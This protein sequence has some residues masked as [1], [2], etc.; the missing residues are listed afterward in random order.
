MNSATDCEPIWQIYREGGAGALRDVTPV[1]SRAALYAALLAYAGG[2][3]AVAR[4]HAAR[5]AEMA[6]GSVLSQEI[7]RYLR[8]DRRD[9]SLYADGE[10][11]AAF[12]RGGGNRFLYERV[13]EA[14][15]GHYRR[16]GPIRLLDIG[17]G[18]G[19]ALLSA[20]DERVIGAGLVGHVDLVEPSA[21]MLARVTAELERRGVAY[22]AHHTT[23]EPFAQKAEGRWDVAQAT[24]S[25]QCIPPALRAEGLAWLRRCCDEL[26][27]AEFDA[28][29]F[30]DEHGPAR[31]AFLLERYERGVTE[32]T[33][34][35]T[36]VAQGFLVPILIGLF[37]GGVNQNFEQ[38]VRGWVAACEQAGFSD[39]RAER[40]CGYWWSDA[41][42]VIAR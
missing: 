27:I 8:Q 17:V 12:I 30:D 35:R 18:D 1:S 28:V 32:Y 26:L 19:L 9:A 11:F 42:L 41:Y 2:E 15:R 40:L 6:P 4:V 20:L 25:L 39:V 3:L 7:G 16:Q 10:A 22:T 36:L 13:A 34:D 5:A 23:L 31:A 24:F 38:P 14:L 29:T 21:P 37:S 33:E